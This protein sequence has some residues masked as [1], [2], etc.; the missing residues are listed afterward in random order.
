VGNEEEAR[1]AAEIERFGCQEGGG[2]GVLGGVGEKR[3]VS[4]NNE[5]EMEGRLT[6][7]Q[8]TLTGFY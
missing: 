6:L 5:E 1:K 8:G 7:L 2:G 4:S 3:N